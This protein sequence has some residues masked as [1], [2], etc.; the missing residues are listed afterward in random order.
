MLYWTLYNFTKRVNDFGGF[1]MVKVTGSERIVIRL[2]LSTVW[3]S[4]LSSEQKISYIKIFFRWKAAIFVVIWQGAKISFLNHLKRDIQQ[5][6]WNLKWRRSVLHVEHILF[7]FFFE[8][9]FCFEGIV[10]LKL[11]NQSPGKLKGS[12]RSEKQLQEN[13][14]HCGTICAL[15]IRILLLVAK[16]TWQ[17]FSYL[18]K[19]IIT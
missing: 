13:I 3:S 2:F 6:W 14:E 4:Y 12:A 5:I 19:F 11:L 10:Y 16:I 15:I 8:D 17:L 18:R 7:L 9:N 1:R